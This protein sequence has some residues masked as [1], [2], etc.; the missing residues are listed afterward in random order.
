MSQKPATKPAPWWKVSPNYDSLRRPQ[1]L[2]AFARWAARNP[3]ERKRVEARHRKEKQT[4]GM[5]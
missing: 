2:G 4:A 3:E 1:K 5:K